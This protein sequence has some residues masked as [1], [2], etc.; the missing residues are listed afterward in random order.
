MTLTNAAPGSPRYPFTAGIEMNQ[1]TCKTDCDQRG[2]RTTH[3]QEGSTM[4]K[5]LFAALLLLPA[6]LQAIGL[7]HGLF[8]SQSTQGTSWQGTAEIIQE[9][10]DITVYADYLDVELEWV[11]KV[12]GTEPDS[13]ANAL[14]IVGNLNLADKST[15]T[16]MITWYKGEILQGK[17]KTVD[18]ARE[19]YE[20]V[21][22]RDSDIPP[23]PRDPVLLEWIRDDNYDI[24]IFPVEFGGTR[25]VRFR[26]LIPAFS[27][28][29]VNKIDYPHAFSSN[30]E[31]SIKKGRG[32]KGYKIET[33]Q[34]IG[35]LMDNRNRVALSRTDYAFESHARWRS[36]VPRIS[37]I[38]PVLY[39]K[40]RGSV[41]YSGA[42]STPGFK[43][44]MSHITTMSGEDALKQAS[45]PADFVIL[46]RWN[47]PTFLEKYAFQ[48]VTQSKMLMSFL[49]QLDE[50][51]QRAALVIDKQGGE[52]ITFK[53][54]NKGDDEYRTMMDYLGE[55]SAQA[56]VTPPSGGSSSQRSIDTQKAFEEF[57]AALASAVEMFE[58]Q[59]SAMKHLLILT[60]GPRMYSNFASSPSISWDSTISVSRFTSFATTSTPSWNSTDAYWPGVDLS[61]FIDENGSRLRVRATVSNG[62]QSHTIDVLGGTQTNSYCSPSSVTQMHLYSSAPLTKE[63]NWSVYDGERLLGEF[64]ETPRSVTVANGDLYACVIGA[65]PHL[66]PLAETMPTSLASTLGFIDETYALVALEED[67]LPV[68]IAAQYDTEGVPVLE[69]NDIFPA[70]EEHYDM[71]VKDWLAA[72]PPEPIGASNCYYMW[73]F[74]PEAMMDMAEPPAAAEK[75]AQARVA[76]PQAE[77]VTDENGAAEGNTS[78]DVPATPLA[79]KDVFRASIVNGKL[80]LTLPRVAKPGKIQIVLY[81]VTGRV[82]TRWSISGETLGTHVSLPLKAGILSSGTYLL[83]VE[84]AGKT[85]ST[86][87]T[88]P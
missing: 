69:S 66:T 32:I 46:W 15:V 16:G 3:I 28:D 71:S 83:R 38:I 70:S 50:A 23:P 35:P 47:N 24:S 17:L 41:I 2:A 19:Q 22:Q 4:K 25:K 13:F 43:G 49:G 65:S 40:T 79:S 5:L 86:V 61:G 63:I 27:H 6:G 44:E 82:I 18:V 36:Q 9:R 75:N 8:R 67:A 12:G 73:R 56:V 30:A 85:W 72:H 10:Y 60:A 20:E 84:T 80:Q 81:D 48:I 11:F 51:G 88:M 31:V 57:E 87:L 58:N 68:E 64:A 42:F 76:T 39:G 53:L 33:S 26:Y 1:S 77:T 7:Q 37:R 78:V 74:A 55:L 34:L 52:R 62:I 54:S 29:G 45:I 14:E 59:T 21:V